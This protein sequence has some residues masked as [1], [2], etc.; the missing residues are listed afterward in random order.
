MEELVVKNFHMFVRHEAA[1]GGENR[2]AVLDKVPYPLR[3]T[4]KIK[5]RVMAVAHPV[6][7][8]EANHSTG[9][10]AVLAM[11]I[12][13]FAGIEFRAD[14]LVVLSVST[15]LEPAPTPRY[16]EPKPPNDGY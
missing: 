10:L 7:T 5:I 13:E 14:L 1:E 3:H 4:K 2:A 16:I 6:G 15:P 8:G 12:G 11:L 9:K